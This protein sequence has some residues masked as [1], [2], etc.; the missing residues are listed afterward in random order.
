[1]KR[2]NWESELQDLSKNMAALSPKERKLPPNNVARYLVVDDDPLRLGHQDGSQ[3][4]H[5]ITVADAIKFTLDLGSRLRGLPDIEDTEIDYK[6]SDVVST[7]WKRHSLAVEVNKCPKVLY[8]SL[9][10]YLNLA[11][12]GTKRSAL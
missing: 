1:M 6:V 7:F 11:T 4:G 9:R 12:A 8:L 2:L 3:G 10:N 5:G